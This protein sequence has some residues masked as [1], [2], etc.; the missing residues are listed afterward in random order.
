MNMNNLNIHDSLIDQEAINN[1]DII[2]SEN[3]HNLY[4]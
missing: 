3:E 4:Q 1:R 2:S